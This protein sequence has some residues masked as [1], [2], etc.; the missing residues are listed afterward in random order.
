MK[1][2]KKALL[3]LLCLSV[4]QGASPQDLPQPGLD[5]DATGSLLELSGCIRRGSPALAWVQEW[6][7]GFRSP[8]FA[9][10]LER[11]T[12]P[13]L[14]DREQVRSQALALARWIRSELR[15]QNEQALLAL[16]ETAIRGQPATCRRALAH[17]AQTLATQRDAALAWA[18]AVDRLVGLDLEIEPLEA[19]A[20]GVEQ[21]LRGLERERARLRAA[22]R[23]R[24]TRGG[25]R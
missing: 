10:L 16:L 5:P 6:L 18:E 12:T 4:V 22:Y 19:S 1:P 8:E 9:G 20:A 24:K 14:G 13:K 15:F 23:H 3:V 7:E 17:V 21:G 11:L 2:S 25:V